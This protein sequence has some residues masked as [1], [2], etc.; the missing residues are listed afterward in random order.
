[1]KDM[2]WKES[3]HG[4]SRDTICKEGEQNIVR[5]SV[6]VAFAC[7]DNGFPDAKVT[8]FHNTVSLR[9]VRRYGNTGNGVA[10]H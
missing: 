3:G 2:I 10:V 5:Q 1:M 8:V 4:T 9:V 6:E 7:F